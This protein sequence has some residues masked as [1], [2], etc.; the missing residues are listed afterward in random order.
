M[1]VGGVLILANRIYAKFGIDAMTDIVTTAVLAQGPVDFTWDD[2]VLVNITSALKVIH[3]EHPRQACK[4]DGRGA[5]HHGWRWVTSLGAD[6]AT[7]ME[8]ATCFGRML[9]GHDNGNVSQ[10][11]DVLTALP[12]MSSYNGMNLC[13]LGSYYRHRN[14]LGPLD[15]TEECW[16]KMRNMGD[17]PR[18]SFDVLGVFS[19][20]DA[21]WMRCSI[22]CGKAATSKSSASL[23]NIKM[24]QL[25]DLSIAA[26]E[27]STL[28]DIQR[29]RLVPAGQMR[30][31]ENVVRVPLTDVYDALLSKIPA[32][33][34][35]QAAVAKCL[36]GKATKGLDWNSGL[37]P[38]SSKRL[39]QSITKLPNPKHDMRQAL[40]SQDFKLPL[41]YCQVHGNVPFPHAPCEQGVGKKRKQVCPQCAAAATRAPK[42]RRA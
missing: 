31:R 38:T 10:Y 16:L 5:L 42:I 37:D 30:S 28:L 8:V 41:A 36:W 34:R 11:F 35:E 20:Q 3:R 13:R 29:K 25:Y 22:I 15:V 27:W 4:T 21:K 6:L 19:L 18:R 14:G 24:F 33:L 39:F 9:L 1:L 12:K 26:C 7:F 40:E 23:A 2:K 17:H 32:S